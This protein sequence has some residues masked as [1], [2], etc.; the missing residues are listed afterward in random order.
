[1]QPVTVTVTYTS[2]GQIAVSGNAP[3]PIIMLGM[4]EMAKSLVARNI[5]KEPGPQ[6]VVAPPNLRF[7]N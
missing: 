6:V 4:L 3:N 2:E 5:G 1:M 7:Q